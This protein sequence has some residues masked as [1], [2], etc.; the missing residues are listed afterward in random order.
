VGKGEKKNCQTIWKRTHRNE[1][2][3]AGGEDPGNLKRKW[4]WER[5]NKTTTEKDPEQF[6]KEKSAK[7]KKTP[8]HLY[9][10]PCTLERQI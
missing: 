1:I 4:G 8:Q 3:G 7:S 9:N 2:E 6:Q 10:S 5:R